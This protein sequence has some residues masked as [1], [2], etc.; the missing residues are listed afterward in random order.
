M[1]GAFYDNVHA[2]RLEVSNLKAR[3]TATAALRRL[4]ILF[5]LIGDIFTIPA[6]TTRQYEAVLTDLGEAGQPGKDWN[7]PLD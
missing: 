5:T 3:R 6:I 2:G 7:F 4:G 1:W